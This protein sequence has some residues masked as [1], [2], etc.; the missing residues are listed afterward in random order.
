MLKGFS[1]PLTPTGR[2]SMVPNPPW[3]YV[4]NAMA[5]EYVADAKK[6]AAFLPEGFEPLDGRCTAFFIDWQTASA[7][8]PE[9]YLNPQYSQYREAVIMMAARYEGRNVSYCPFIWVDNDG[10]ALRGQVYGYPKQIAQVFMTRAYN[11]ASQAA[12]VIGPGG[13]LA[14]YC[15]ADCGRLFDAQIELKEPAAGAPYPHFSSVLSLRHFPNLSRKDGYA[16]LV[17]DLVQGNCYDVHVAEAWKGTASLHVYD[18]SVPELAAFKPLSVTAGYYD[19]ESHT[20][21]DIE[22]IRS[23][24]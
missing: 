23:Y 20:T 11:V 21:D 17:M 10:A 2:S 5:I 3:Y 16:P 14:A 9:A 15:A 1:V 22:L 18:T 7:D 4:G 12:P 6:T 8:D 19:V 13:R 24:R